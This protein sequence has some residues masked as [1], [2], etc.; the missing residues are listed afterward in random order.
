MPADAAGAAMLAF[1]ID[2]RVRGT[3]KVSL[4]SAVDCELA[5]ARPTDLT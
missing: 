3:A 4:R 5:Y 2:H 1:H